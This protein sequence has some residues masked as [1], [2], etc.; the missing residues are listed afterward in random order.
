MREVTSWY[1]HRLQSEM[2]MIRWGHWGQP[3]LLFPTAGGDAAEVERMDLI[4]ALRPLIDAGRI[5]V[6]SIDSFAG[7]T[8]ITHRHNPA[9]CVWV[10]KQFDAYIREE[11]VPAIR[12]DCRSDS[13]EIMTAGASI[14]AFNAVLSICRHPDVFSHAIGM[15]GTYDIEHW[16]GG[17][18]IQDFYHY[19]PV[20]FLPQVPDGEHLNRLRTRS[21]ILATGQG[22]W[23]NPGDSWKVAQVLGGRGVPNRVDLWDPQWDHDWP[24]WRIMLP[25]YLDKVVAP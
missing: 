10:Q 15:S 22:P 21:V 23:E 20:H 1:S 18:S 9:H 4:A 12:M 13:V 5:K 25:Q 17:H 16:L 2:P 6:Y 14:G 19:S 3:L 8:W 7:R 24:T 11:V